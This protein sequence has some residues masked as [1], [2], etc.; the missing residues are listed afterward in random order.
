LAIQHACFV[1]YR[2]PPPAAGGR[3]Y[4]HAWVSFVQ[5][6]VSLLVKN[7]AV[8]RSVYWD[9]ELRSK[10]GQKYP[11]TLAHN[12]CTSACMVAILQ[13][14]YLESEWCRAEWRAMEQLEQARGQAAAPGI[15][16]PILYRGDDPQVGAFAGVRPPLDF[17]NVVLPKQLTTSVR[18]NSMLQ[19][20]CKHID[21]RVR[22]IHETGVDCQSWRIAVGEEKTVGSVQDPNPVHHGP[23]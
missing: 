2:H 11:E 16:I 6:I 20:T 13:P 3:Q 7:L 15:I 17:R 22:A 21:E 4:E 5:T 10:A 18:F 1:S 8:N 9:L 19:K 23:V 14:E 12:L